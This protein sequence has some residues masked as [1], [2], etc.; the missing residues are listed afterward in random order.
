MGKVG[1]ALNMLTILGSGRTYTIRELSEKMEVSPKSVRLY[2]DAL[3]SA[4]IYVL[5]KRGRD[6]GYYLPRDLQKPLLGLAISEE[7]LLALE[8]VSGELESARH[9]EARNVTSVLRKVQAAREHD[10]AREAPPADHLSHV[11]GGARPNI[12][13]AREREKLV[14]VLMARRNRRKIRMQYRPLHGRE[15]ERTVHVYS[16]YTYRGEIY[17]VAYCELRGTYRD[18][19][20]RRASRIRVLDE[21][22]DLDPTF[23][24]S[25]YM[26]HCIGIFKGDP[27]AL[28]VR[29]EEPMAQIVREMIYSETQT[30]TELEGEEAIL[31]EAVMR[32]RQEILS[33]IL[34]MGDKA[35]VISPED[36]RDEVADQARRI[37][38]A[39]AGGRPGSD[40]SKPRKRT[41][42]RGRNTK[43]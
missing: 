36:L 38:D 12:D 28:A 3:D 25:R 7:E 1:N 5:E 37:A 6:G 13:P 16:T 39:Y 23:S 20:L 43:K 18:F 8:I 27:I 24:L 29:V 35:T 42:Q 14:Q 9:V 15:E 11:S 17:L 31:F 10:R 2:R 30:I 33:W 41:A 32:G 21:R 4:G 26:E 40:A 22:Y 19:K 34:G